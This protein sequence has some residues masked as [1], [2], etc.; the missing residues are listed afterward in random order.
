M[1]TLT[2][3]EWTAAEAAHH[4]RVEAATA[5][6]RQRR[7]SGVKHPVEDFLFTYYSHSPAQLRRWHPGVGSVLADGERPWKFYVSDARGASV[8]VAAFVEARGDTVRFVRRLLAATM[9][10]TPTLGCFGLHEWAMVYRLGA[11][12]VRHA[13]WPLRLSPAETD[14]VVDRH[15]VRC[16]HFDAFR[17]FT[18]PARP[19]NSLAPTRD[20]QVAMEQPGCLH[21]GMDVYKWAYKLTPAVPSDLVMDCFDLARDIRTLDMAAAPYDLRDLGVDPVPIETA[22]GKAEYVR[23]Q[24]EFAGRGN[25]LRRRLIAVCDDVLDA[26]GDEHRSDVDERCDG[27]PNLA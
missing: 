21:A 22:A 7:Q 27:F 1:I 24:R 26:C 17:F 4:A 5:G 11:D 14:A 10:R 20:S 18:E 3:D 8:D 15:Q 12:D 19:L 2:R 23:Q 25:A 13:D 6:H 9:G 16:S